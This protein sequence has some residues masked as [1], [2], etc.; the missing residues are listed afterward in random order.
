MI[1]QVESFQCSDKQVTPEECQVIQRTKRRVS[2]Y[3]FKDEDNISKSPNQNNTHEALSK[4]Q[5]EILF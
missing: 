4:T 5:T 3:H 2:T 1:S